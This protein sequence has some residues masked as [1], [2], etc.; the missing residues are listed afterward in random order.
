MPI[1]YATERITVNSAQL[2]HWNGSASADAISLEGPCPECGDATA[3]EIPRRISDLASRTD[4]QQPPLLTIEIACACTGEHPGRPSG[5]TSGCGRSWLAMAAISSNG[6]VTL[7][8]GPSTDPQVAAAAQALRAAGP[9]QL[10]DIRAAA[11]KWIGGLTTLFGLFGL[12][13]LVTSRSTLTSLATGW[14]AIIAIGV[15]VAAGLA[16]VAIYRIYRAAYGWPMTRPV[17]NDRELLAWYAAQEAAP[18]VQASCLRDGV[19][20]AG[21]ALVALIITAG[22]LLLAPPKTPTVPFVQITLTDGSQ[23]CGTLLPATP[24]ATLI[25]RAGDGNSVNLAPRSFEAETVLA[26]C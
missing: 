6:T 4:Q 18:R 21:G 16:G 23:V 26:T 17:S 22:L 19:R 24:G 15:V 12:A 20:A 13:G 2:V 8:P 11:E 7:A 14:Q 25:R 5:L 10:A 9:K 1:T 3:N